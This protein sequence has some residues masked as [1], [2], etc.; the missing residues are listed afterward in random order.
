MTAVTDM[1]GLFK[2][3]YS[4]K[5]ERLTPK[6]DVIARDIPFVAAEQ[7]EGNSFHQP[8]VI[9]KEHGM[10]FNTD[11]SAFTLN[12]A[13]SSTSKDANVTGAEFVLRSTLSYAAL[14]KAM[15]SE[16]ESQVRAFVNATSYMVENM[17]ETSSY[18]R[19]VEILY[20]SGTVTSA[21]VATQGLGQAE[22]V[23]TGASGTVTFTKASWA[24]GIWAGTEGMRV[25]FRS[26]AG[27]VHETA[28][29]HVVTAVNFTTRTVTFTALGTDV[30]IN[31]VAFFG[32]SNGASSFGKEMAGLV[33]IANNTGSLFGISATTYALWRAHTYSAGSGSLVF[34]KVV[35]ALNGPAATGL[36]GDINLYVAV[37][38]WSDLNNDLAALRRFS[39][40][41]GGKI[42]QGAEEIS[43][44]SHTGS[45][46]IKP[47]IYIKQGLA[48]A[49]K[50]DDVMRLGATDIT[51]EMPVGDNPGKIFL[52]TAD[53][54]GVEMRTYWNQCILHKK[55]AQLLMITNIV[56]SDDA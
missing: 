4:K 42:E 34:P 36:K 27:A 51:F 28:A 35:K 50:P 37:S 12:A 8:V 53:S 39:D 24:P 20:G 6:T 31:D 3:V 13:I 46:K 41:A 10:T 45:I 5:V 54:A 14:Q 38:T 47:H 21:A 52:H 48:L 18:A 32:K 40:K 29:T 16:G 9:A 11:G 30:A 55:P 19:E 2:R 1:D 23:T 15:K 7:R 56:N 26:L 44:Y 25:E 43:Y 49:F 17:T 33:M 22:A